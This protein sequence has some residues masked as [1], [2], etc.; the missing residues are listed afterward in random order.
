MPTARLAVNE[1]GRVSARQRVIE[2]C[3]EIR[4]ELVPTLPGGR[5]TALFDLGHTMVLGLVGTPEDLLPM[6]EKA[7]RQDGEITARGRAQS[8]P[9]P[10]P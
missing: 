10:H 4:V 8:S 2:A 1:G 5:R 7:L 9:P 3:P 6:M